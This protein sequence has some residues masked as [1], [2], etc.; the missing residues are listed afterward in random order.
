MTPEK[1]LS[2]IGPE[3][4]LACVGRLISIVEVDRQEQRALPG[5]HRRGDADPAREGH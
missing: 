4:L 5:R 1:M 3:A 2:W